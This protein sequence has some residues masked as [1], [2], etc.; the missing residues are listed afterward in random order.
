MVKID[1]NI[2]WAAKEEIM[3][4]KFFR[5]RHSEPDEQLGEDLS[6]VLI[7]VYPDA[8]DGPDTD[9]IAAAR[10]PAHSMIL[11]NRSKYFY[12]LF[13]NGMVQSKLKDEDQVED[14]AGRKD[15]SPSDR[16]SIK[17]KS[18]ETPCPLCVS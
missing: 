18:K 9:K 12:T 11:A 7:E 8:S 13:T 6:G 4:K 10:I 17:S 14:S 3:R 15:I 5:T 2:S 1:P 16:R